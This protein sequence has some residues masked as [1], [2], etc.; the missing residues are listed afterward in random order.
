[1]ALI[2][3]HVCMW[4]HYYKAI[5]CYVNSHYSILYKFYM[6]AYTLIGQ[7]SHDSATHRQRNL[8]AETTLSIPQM[9]HCNIATEVRKVRIP[10]YLYM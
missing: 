9:F 5:M 4:V 1:M 3:L 7:I 6:H 10:T 2:C 8:P